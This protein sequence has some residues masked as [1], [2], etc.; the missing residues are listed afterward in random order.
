MS[1]TGDGGRTAP[2]ASVVVATH[3]RAQS[4]MT[5]LSVVLAEAGRFE[6]LV[7]DDAST[8]DTYYRL[9]ALSEQDRRV[10]PI[11]VEKMGQRAATRAGV[12]RSVGRV[13]IFLDDDI[14]PE[15]GIVGR[16]LRRHDGR[17]D[18]IVIG[19]MPTDV[20]T[21][22]QPGSFATWLY[23]ESY[24]R[25][26]DAY[27]RDPGTILRN[28]WMG[29]V[30]MSKASYLRALGE[31]A[32]DF[33]YRHDDREIGLLCASAGLVAE[34]DPTIRARHTYARSLA[35]FVLD[36]RS[37]GAGDATLASRYPDLVDPIGP[38][39]TSGLRGPARLV[40]LSARNQ[41]I[42]RLASV[43][44]QWLVMLGGRVRMRSVELTSARVLRRLEQ[45]YGAQTWMA[46]Q[47]P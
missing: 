29:N 41:T 45:H 27:Q 11:R 15:P 19:Y 16:H 9:R 47:A 31:V 7:V 40:V 6:V 21:R 22:W 13:L 39:R 10:Q 23:A 42:H 38:G 36:C 35:Q 17:D 14:L 25:R 44:V 12:E 2:E 34:F 30:S 24:R 26:C 18:L 28:L 5:M 32:P 33:P 43:A 1:V 8:D 20:P 46:G 4:L 3:N 37:E